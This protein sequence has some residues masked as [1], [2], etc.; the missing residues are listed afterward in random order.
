MLR[1]FRRSLSRD[2]DVAHVE[3]AH[4]G[5]TYRVAL[6]R[7]TTARRFTLRVRA[8]TR[9]VVLTMPVRGST[10]AAREFALHFKSVGH[11]FSHASYASWALA[12]SMVNQHQPSNGTCG[13]NFSALGAHLFGPGE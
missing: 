10:L 6:K 8:A 12:P 5:E 11:V 7:V 1:L 2:A 13:E 9:D 3:V 4:S